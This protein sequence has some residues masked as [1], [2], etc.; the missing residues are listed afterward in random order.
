VVDLAVT[1]NYFDIRHIVRMGKKGG[2]DTKED[3][4]KE[5]IDKLKETF[6]LE[7]NEWKVIHHFHDFNDDRFCPIY[8]NRGYSG[9]KI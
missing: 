2:T 8:T 1:V 3:T 9:C 5:D 4:P 6:V 7:K